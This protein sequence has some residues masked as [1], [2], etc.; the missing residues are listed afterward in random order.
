[1]TQPLQKDETVKRSLFDIFFTALLLFTVKLFL[2]ACGFFFTGCLLIYD[3]PGYFTTGIILTILW[4]PSGYALFFKN[5]PFF[6]FPVRR[7]GFSSGDG[8]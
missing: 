7:A 4:A 3:A 1:M 2:Y 6:G 5:K 8:I